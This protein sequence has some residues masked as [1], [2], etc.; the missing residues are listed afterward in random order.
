[1]GHLQ[2]NYVKLLHLWTVHWGKEGEDFTCHLPSAVGQGLTSWSFNFPVL[3]GRMAGSCANHSKSHA[4]VTTGNPGVEIERRAARVPG[5]RWLSGWPT[6]SMT[7]QEWG[8]CVHLRCCISWVQHSK[9][10]IGIDSELPKLINSG[11]AVLFKWLTLVSL[12]SFSVSFPSSASFSFRLNGSV[13]RPRATSL[14]F[15]MFSLDSCIHFHG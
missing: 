6:N 12:V 4:S 7:D 15:Y 1:M 10:S 8:H 9:L 2:R 11:P 13:P 3:L 5:K 14:S